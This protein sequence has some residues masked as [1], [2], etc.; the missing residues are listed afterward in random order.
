[1]TCFKVNFKETKQSFVA[2]FEHFQGGSISEP[3]TGEYEL[4]PTPEEQVLPVKNKLM[5]EDFVVHAIP[6]EYGLVTYN[7]D[8]VITIT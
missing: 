1:M 6:K 7:Q 2:K 8:K 5:T 3:Y 4:T